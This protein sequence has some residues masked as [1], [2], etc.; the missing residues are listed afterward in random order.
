MN[1]DKPFGRWLTTILKKSDE[2]YNKVLE[3]FE[4]DSNQCGILIFLY[5]G[6]EGSTQDE[7]AFKF[8]KDK[9]LISR[10]LKGLEKLGYILRKHD[11]DDKRYHRIFLSEKGKAV[12]KKIKSIENEWYEKLME[13]IPEENLINLVDSLERIYDNALRYD[14]EESK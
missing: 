4:L 13:G 10:N 8:N 5:F 11:E 2:F 7:I 1:L 12:K 6:G 3:D 14:K 9:S